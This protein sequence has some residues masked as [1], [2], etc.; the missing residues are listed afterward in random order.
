MQLSSGSHIP[1]GLLAANALLSENPR[2]GIPSWESAPHQGISEANCTAAIGSRASQH[3]NRVQ[4]RYTGKERDAESGLDY[5]GARYY[6]SNMGRWMSP[7]WAD[8]PEAV[9]YS[10]LENPQSLNLYGYVL[11]NPLSQVDADGHWPSCDWCHRANEAFKGVV[12]TAIKGL[13]DPFIASGNAIRSGDQNA[14]TTQALGMVVGAATPV[15]EFGGSTE[16]SAEATGLVETEAAP[17]TQLQINSA[18]GAAWEDAVG[19]S[20]KQGDPNTA[21]QVTLKTESGVRTRMD[22]VS[23]DASGNV[24]LTEAKSSAT[25]PLTPNQAAA[26]PEI[27]RTGATVVGRGKPGYPG[28]TQIPPTNVQVVRPPQ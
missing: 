1:D 14:A 25:A 13:L 23:K 20:L 27:A 18:N 8:K 19:A 6:A 9:P 15:P 12:R 17:M 7:D 16:V 5:F 26:H 21:A 11:N 10:S 28:G 2:L 3:L 4:S 24:A 22:F